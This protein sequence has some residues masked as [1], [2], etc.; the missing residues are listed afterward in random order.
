MVTSD[1]VILA[2]L[3]GELAR[4]ALRFTDAGE[5]RI[6]LWASDGPVVLDVTDDGPGIPIGEQA[7]IFG[8]FQRGELAAERYD[9]AAGLG[10]YLACA[11]ASLLGLQ[12][13]LASQAGAGS[14]FSIT[15]PPARGDLTSEPRTEP[16]S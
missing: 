8:P 12:L 16:R 5:V 3:L 2:P 13:G 9:G 11:Q 15:F 10:L 6:R 7:R 4:N 14:T 1:P